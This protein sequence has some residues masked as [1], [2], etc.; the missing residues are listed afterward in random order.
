MVAV[1]ARGRLLDSGVLEWDHDLF[2][3][4]G[5]DKA[6]GLHFWID[7]GDPDDQSS[8]GHQFP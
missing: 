7:L 1:L 8:D 6:G 2:L 4:D 5:A 3:A